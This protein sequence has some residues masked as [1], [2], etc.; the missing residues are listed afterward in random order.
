MPI[1]DQGKRFCKSISKTMRIFA[2][3]LRDKQMQHA[4]EEAV[5]LASQ[6]CL[7]QALCF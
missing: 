5:K 3:M 4:E 7:F 1:K 2:E 6:K